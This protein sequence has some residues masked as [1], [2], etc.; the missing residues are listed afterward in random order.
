MSKVILECESLIYKYKLDKEA[1]IEQ[2]KKIKIERDK[3]FITAYNKDFRYV[4]IGEINLKDNSIVLINI[5]KAIAYE[6]VDNSDILGM[7]SK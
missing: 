7:V 5:E 2:L 3:D 6:E 1:I 4:L